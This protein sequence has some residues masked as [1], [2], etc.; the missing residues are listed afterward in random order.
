MHIYVYVYVSTYTYI[1]TYTHHI[2]FIPSSVDG[3]FGFFHTW[4]IV[5][6]A[7]MNT[8]VMYSFKLVFPSDKYSEV[9]LLDYMVVLFLIF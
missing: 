5:N 2:F 4:T 1:N 3:H 7:A 6:N 9:K 8:E